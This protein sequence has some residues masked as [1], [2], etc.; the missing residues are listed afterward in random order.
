MTYFNLGSFYFA[1]DPKN[2]VVYQCKSDKEQTIC[3][4]HRY[5]AAIN[6]IDQ[7]DENPY[8]KEITADEFQL[9]FS[10]CVD[11]LHTSTPFA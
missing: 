5:K 3:N 10:N 6:V 4:V 9:Q 7:L 8:L 11:K 1:V 2:T